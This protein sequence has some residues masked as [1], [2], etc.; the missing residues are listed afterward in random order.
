MDQRY[1]QWIASP[2]LVLTMSSLTSAQ[3][4]SQTQLDTLVHQLDHL[5]AVNNEVRLELDAARADL[6]D[7]WHDEQRSAQVASIVQEIINDA[8]T[9]TNLRGGGLMMGWSN[10]FF[11]S[12]ADGRHT[13][14][15]SGMM[16]MRYMGSWA[17]D[18]S[19]RLIDDWQSGF[20]I[21]RVQFNITGQLATL[22]MEYKIETGWGRVDPDNMTSN[23]TEMDQ[24]LFE[25]WSKFKFADNLA[26]K[27]GQFNLPFTRE[28]L[29]A[30]AHQL[31]IEKTIIDH[32]V[33]LGMSTGVEFIWANQ[34]QRFF[35]AYTNGSGAMLW[36]TPLMFDEPTSS[37]P[38]A[39]IN[40]D[41]S[42]S[43]TARHEWKLSGNWEQFN[44]FTSP[45]GTGK[46]VL[47]GIAGHQQNLERDSEEPTGGFPDGRMS[48]VT[49]DVS[50]QL[51]GAS[52]FV[53][54]TFHRMK[55]FGP[56]SYD[57]D[58][59]GFVAQGSSYLTNSIEIYGRLEVGGISDLPI[60]NTDLQ[61][62]T[63]GINR[64]LNGQDVK[65][66]ADVGYS[67]GELSGRFSNSLTGWREDDERRNQVVYRT[68]L[69][70]M[71]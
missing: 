29:I 8:D 36:S 49:A 68:Q 61:V 16:Q 53:S 63:I 60:L 5:E 28:T 64:Y 15:V 26:I 27:I 70:V 17:Q 30:P 58:W 44:Q 62:A 37:P 55:E 12:S 51:D 32:R 1:L 52:F 33:G 14:K 42:Y 46:G 3:P 67:F 43:F 4:S 25:V 21:P 24:R 19:K 35:L 6:S 13:L 48:S 59:Y 18:E 39:A 54:G 31:A 41:T 66:S 38:W 45:P 34:Q 22:G 40:R 7:G 69:Q 10:G 50:V 2:I 71:F 65:L 47:L 23:D 9:R 56:G 11:L 20:D 57:F